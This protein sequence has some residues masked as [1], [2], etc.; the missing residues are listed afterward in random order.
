M[1]RVTPD[2]IARILERMI[3]QPVRRNTDARTPGEQPVAIG[4]DE[5]REPPPLPEMSMKPEAATHRM[6]HALSSVAELEPIELER[7]RILRGR[8]GARRE[9]R[10]AH[11]QATTPS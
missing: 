3:L 7:G 4:R 11:W 10:V 9:G 6:D 1:P 2:V 8:Q 5:V